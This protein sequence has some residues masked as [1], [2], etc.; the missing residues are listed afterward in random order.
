MIS[1]ARSPMAITVTLVGARTIVGMIGGVHDAQTIDAV[2]A[3]SARRRRARLR[4]R[5]H[6][7]GAG[8]RD[9]T[10]RRTHAR[11][12]RARRRR[13]NPRRRAPDSDRRSRS[14]PR[15]RRCRGSGA[16]RRPDAAR[17]TDRRAGSSRSC[18]CAPGS[19][20]DSTTRPRLRGS[21]TPHV[22]TTTT[23]APTTDWKSGE[24]LRSQK[25]IML[26]RRSLTAPSL[27]EEQRAPSWNCGAARSGAWRPGC[28]KWK[29]PG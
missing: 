18:G 26:S 24:P 25:F 23:G 9:T 29:R 12:D 7:T 28:R 3:Q 13:R 4:V 11:N 21:C 5:T 17:R 8:P 19:G 22:S 1:A 20:D 10:A 15:T 27:A 2:H 14:S 16:S 6:P